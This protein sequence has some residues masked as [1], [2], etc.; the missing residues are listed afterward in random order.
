MASTNE[1]KPITKKELEM[2]KQELLGRL[3]SKEDLKQLATKK[4]FEIIASQVSNLTHRMTSV[5]NQLS[6][7]QDT[8][9]L[10][11]ETVADIAKKFYDAQT[12]KAATNHTLRRHENRLEDHEKGIKT[13]EKEVS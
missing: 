9:N 5:E 2:T 3:A 1:Q 10:I 4:D 6:V 12:E 11:L 8:S 13:I 7:V